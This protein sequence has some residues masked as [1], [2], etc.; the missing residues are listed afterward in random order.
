MIDV[1]DRVLDRGIVIDAEV[2][3]SLVGLNL[4]GV[5][6]RIVVSCIETYLEYMDDIA[7]TAPASWSRDD[8]EEPPRTPLGPT[9][10]VS[11]R[12]APLLDGPEGPSEPDIWRP[13]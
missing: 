5:E 10:D 8:R 6:A 9:P 4:V 11:N 12:I 2:N 1:L 7:S 13:E 3:V